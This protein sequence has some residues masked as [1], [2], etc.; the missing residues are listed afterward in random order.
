MILDIGN[1]PVL[2]LSADKEGEIDKNKTGETI[3]LYYII[4]IF[5]NQL[6]PQILGSLSNLYQTRN[7]IKNKIFEE[8]K[9]LMRSA[10]V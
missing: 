6:T 4:I 5:Y 9:L 1:R 10:L 7:F 3:F 8:L 2:D